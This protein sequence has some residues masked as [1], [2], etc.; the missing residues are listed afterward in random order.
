MYMLRS[1]LLA[2]ACVSTA[3]AQAVSPSTEPIVLDGTFQDWGDVPHGDMLRAAADDTH[4]Y[5]LL[6]IPGGPVNL[7]GLDEPGILMLN[8]DNDAATGGRNLA[9]P[10]AD[11]EITFSP[12][13]GGRSGGA[14]IR[15]P[16]NGNTW[17]QPDSAALTFAPTIAHNRFEIRLP[18]KLRTPAESI[19]VSDTLQWASAGSL[20]SQRGSCECGLLR[21]TP[22][23]AFDAIPECPTNATRVV[24]WNVEFGGILDHPAPF[25]RIMRALKPHIVLL[26]ELEPKQA[27]SDI[28]AVLKDGVPG[29]W[30]VDLGPTGGALRSAVATRLPAKD[31]PR[32]DMLKRRDSPKRGVRAAAL[33]VAIPGVG[34]VAMVSLH[35]KCCG[36]AEGPE[37]MTRIAE[38]I[39]VRRALLDAQ[40]KESLDGVVLGGDLNL[41]GSSRPLDLL[42][43]DGEADLGGEG[44]FAIANA[45]RPS[46]QGF[47]TWEKAGQRYTP[48][49]L[50]WI[51]YSGSSL[52]AVNAFVLATEELPE[53]QLQSHGLNADDAARAAD[54]LP[55]VVD[56]A[57]RKR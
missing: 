36:V 56:V 41:V 43:F 44:D 51:V 49:R 55:V 21:A 3:L 54:H 11:L 52:Q 33:R 18:K 35:L 1:G 47:Q 10:G 9:L 14:Q 20:G 30:T 48:G 6:S 53:S 12:S 25:V 13:A 45:I 4:L 27:A 46:A 42:I 16:G 29:E 15:F 26:Q 37:D 28:E 31:M 32:I 38:V 34:E 40:R 19:L 39:A 7:Q 2:I 24:S 23:R 8:L 5:L 50:D 17:L 22:Q 57:P